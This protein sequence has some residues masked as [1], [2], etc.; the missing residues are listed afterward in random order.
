[1]QSKQELLQ[2]K[3]FSK[4]GIV[5]DWDAVEKLWNH[6]FY[7]VL[8]I[9]PEEHAILVTEK[10][11]NHKTNRA[12]GTEIL[13]EKVNT[14]AL[15]WCA[16][17]LLSLYSTG[18]STGVTLEIGND[19]SNVASIYEGYALP[20]SKFRLNIG[21]SHIT[22]YL[23]QLIEMKYKDKFS[24]NFNFN[25]NNLND[26]T[27]FKDIKHKMCYFAM[28]FEKEITNAELGDNNNNTNN[29]NNNNNTYQLPDGKKIE[30]DSELFQ[31]CEILFKPNFVGVKDEMIRNQQSVNKNKNKNKNDKDK[32]DESKES[33]TNVDIDNRT[34]TGISRLI[35]QSIISCDV[36][37]RR[38]LFENMYICGGSSAIKN[39]DARL[40]QELID[41]APQNIKCQAKRAPKYSTWIGGSILASLTTFS[42][43]WCT[44]DEYD[45]LGT[46]IVDRKCF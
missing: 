8:R 6:T 29:N 41:F 10:P 12:N 36:D 2:I 34:L 14:P 46:K 1:M 19:C 40:S 15:L 24:N 18:T 27:L 17:N 16:S 38:D 37:I 3:T 45:E 42:D 33:H 20:Q 5:T 32:D 4:H 44:K 26:I 23:M 30:L 13:F 7:N 9:H 22:Q 31:C 39:I 35:Y 43:L 28:D 21:G 11:H 25:K